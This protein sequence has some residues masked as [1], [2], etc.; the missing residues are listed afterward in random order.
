MCSEMHVFL[1]YA[2]MSFDKHIHHVAHYETVEDL[3]LLCKFTS[4]FPNTPSLSPTYNDWFGAAHLEFHV[5]L[6]R[7]IL[8]FLWILIKH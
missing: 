1:V 2:L 7:L 4:S 6:C 5:L 3:Y 8:H